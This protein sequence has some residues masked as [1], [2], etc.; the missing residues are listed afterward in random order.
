MLMPAMRATP[1]LPLPLLVTGVLADDEHRTVTADDLALF[2]HR[3]DRS[4]DLHRS[5][6]RSL[7][8]DSVSGPGDGRK[9]DREG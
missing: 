6:I 3:L 4:S 2:A 9:R 5:A 1:A 7:G 8:K